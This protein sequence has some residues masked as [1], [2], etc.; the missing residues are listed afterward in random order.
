MREERKGC[1]FLLLKY[2]LSIALLW[3]RILLNLKLCDK[4]LYLEVIPHL[5]SM[6]LGHWA[7]RPYLLRKSVN[8]QLECL[9]N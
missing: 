7:F 1:P 5:S 2:Y 8:Q 9:A 6:A 3:P 4:D